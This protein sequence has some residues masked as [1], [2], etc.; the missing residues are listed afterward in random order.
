MVEFEFLG[1]RQA[2]VSLMVWAWC[3]DDEEG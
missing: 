1:A 3:G 2:C